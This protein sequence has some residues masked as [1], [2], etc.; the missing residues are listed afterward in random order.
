[1]TTEGNALPTPEN[2]IPISEGDD[3]GRGSLVWFNQATMY[4]ASETGH[5]SV[6]NAKNAG[7]PGT[8]NYGKDAQQ[9]FTTFGAFKPV[10][11]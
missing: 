9:A 7:H 11:D 5:Q 8:A 1:V 10:F 3:E 6:K 4:Q 2:S